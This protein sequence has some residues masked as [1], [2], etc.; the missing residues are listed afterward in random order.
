MLALTLT[1]DLA[2]DSLQITQSTGGFEFVTCHGSSLVHYC[3]N[4]SERRDTR[5]HRHIIVAKGTLSERVYP[6]RFCSIQ[7]G[8][9]SLFPSFLSLLLNTDAQRIG[10]RL[11][12]N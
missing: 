4:L 10:Y 1:G 7:L 11:G 8:R 12:F 9:Y 5:G 2:H 6:G 3:D